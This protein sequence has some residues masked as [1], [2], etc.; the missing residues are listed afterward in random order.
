LGVKIYNLGDVQIEAIVNGTGD[1]IVLLAA[2]GQDAVA[3]NQITPF[4]NK[5]GYKTVAINRRGIGGS[6]GPLEDISL[7]DL[8]SDVAK[9]IQMIG[10]SLV[11]VLGWA[12][13][14]RIARCISE[15]YP[16]LVKSVILLAAGGK[17]LPKPDSSKYFR[18]LRNSNSSKEERINAIRFLYFS[19]STDMDTINNALR[20]KSKWTQARLAHEKANQATPLM[21]W[22]NG[23]KA[24]K[25]VIQGLDDRS[26]VP[27]NGTLLKKEQGERVKLVNLKD[28]GHFMVYQQ[29]QR[30]AEEII[31]FLSSLS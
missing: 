16:E 7:H 23:G 31:L 28:T 14:N 29:P 8:A 18:V 20:G 6:K 26:A 12:F 25:L 5:A 1:I 24:P 30:V 27:E 4:L 3:F 10:E 19:P 22:W 15:D 11:H 17:V 13:G 2:G 21:D 9:V